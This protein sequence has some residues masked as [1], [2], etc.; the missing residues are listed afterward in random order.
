MSTKLSLCVRMVAFARGR[1]VVSVLEGLVVADLILRLCAYGC[2][3]LILVFLRISCI[4]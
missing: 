3:S 1:D 2:L 4:S